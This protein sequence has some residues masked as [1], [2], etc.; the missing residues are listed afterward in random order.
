MKTTQYVRQE[1]AITAADTSGIRE[2]W[3]WG[4]RLLRD[5]E[6]MASTSSLRHGV[7]AQLIAAAGKDSHGRNRLG[8]QEIQRRLRCARAYSTEFEI[9]AALTDFATWDDLARA[10][11]PAFEVPEDEP[12]ADHRT[13]VELQRDHVRALEDLVGEQGALFPASDFEPIATPLKTLAEYA[14][15][16]EEWTGRHVRRD[17]ERRDYLNRLIAAA[18]GDLSVTW[19]AAHEQAFGE[20]A[21]A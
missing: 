9:R 7:A 18:A 15:E 2:R 5:S 19:Q 8:E 6:A 3:M 16:M 14:D 20:A 12:L 11:F 21:V 10:G 4:L 1:R 13:D 17:R